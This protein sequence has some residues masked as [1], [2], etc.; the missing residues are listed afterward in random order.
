MSNAYIN[1]K[2]HF[3]S[4]GNDAIVAVQKLEGKLNNIFI[5]E[6]DKAITIC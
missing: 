6:L 4:G 3:V 5:T 2:V 1:P